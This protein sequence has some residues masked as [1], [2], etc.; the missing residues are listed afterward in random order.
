MN[1]TFWMSRRR[2]NIS[3]VIQIHLGSCLFCIPRNVL[4]YD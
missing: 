4:R 2:H 1:I 3:I